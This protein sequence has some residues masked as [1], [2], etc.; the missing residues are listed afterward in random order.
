M[1]GRV[2]FV[3]QLKEVLE[4]HCIHNQKAEDDGVP[5]VHVLLCVPAQTQAQGM[6]LPTLRVGLDKSN[7]LIQINPYKHW[8]RHVS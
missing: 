3:S 7:S 8:Q 4:T 5:A 2:D 6:V 1:G